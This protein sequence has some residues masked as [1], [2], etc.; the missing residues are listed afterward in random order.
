M[1]EASSNAIE[2]ESDAMTVVTN[3]T[4]AT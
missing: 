4:V 2:A 3:G 1:H